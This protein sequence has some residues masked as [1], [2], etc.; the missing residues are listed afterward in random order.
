MDTK[1]S[2]RWLAL[3]GVALAALLCIALI[4][5]SGGAPSGRQAP[6]PQ[7]GAPERIVRS[8]SP[9]AMALPTPKEPAS[10]A[11]AVEPGRPARPSGNDR[12]VARPAARTPSIARDLPADA[13]QAQILS[14]IPLAPMG[15]RPSRSAF[16]GSPGYVPPNDSEADAAVVGRREAP[17]VDREFVGG[18]SSAEELAGQILDA[19]RMKDKKALGALRITADEFGEILWPEFPASRPITRLKAADAWFFLTRIASRGPTREWMS[20]GGRA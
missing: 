13:G 11:T 19:L 3:P 9:P 20:S 1:S 16:V 14:E 15:E 18:A 12:V 4:K 8:S 6:A 10:E 7:T 17:R 5:L 2:N